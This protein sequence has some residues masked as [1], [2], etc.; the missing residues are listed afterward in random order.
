MTPN[1][2]TIAGGLAAAVLGSGVTA[3]LLLAPNATSAS[4]PTSTEVT[5]PDDTSGTADSETASARDALREVLQPLVDAGALTAEEADAIVDELLDFA[6]P[7]FNV[8]IGPGDQL[9]PGRPGP[10]FPGM[11]GGR[12]EDGPFGGRLRL[13][14][15]DLVADA[16][17]ID[18]TDLIAQLAQGA[19]V[20]EIAEENGVDPQTAV[21]ALVDDYTQRVTDWVN[22]D[23]TSST[24]DET[25]TTTPTTEAAA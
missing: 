14:R 9:V 10:N 20:A 11:P 1:P 5:S 23:D 7:S 15:A 24:E 12:H 25:A 17:G 21:D 16:I 2:R 4:T 19:T 6:R 3:A 22:G 13:F 8:E 18:E